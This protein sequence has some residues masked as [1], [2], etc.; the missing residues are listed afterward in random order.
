[1]SSRGAQADVMMEALLWIDESVPEVEI[2]D[3][4]HPIWR[5]L[6]HVSNLLRIRSGGM[7]LLADHVKSIAEGFAGKFREQIEGIV[8]AMQE[9]GMPHG[10]QV[11]L[12]ELGRHM[13]KASVKL[14][15][16]GQAVR[17]IYELLNE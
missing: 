14:L 5:D 2:L 16:S 12:R 10:A 9:A 8:A 4:T 7:A 1:M 17:R 6:G 15:K 3:F 13:D 11:W